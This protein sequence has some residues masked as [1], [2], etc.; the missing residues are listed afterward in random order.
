MLT[1]EYLSFFICVGSND[2]S[3]KGTA[4]YT[5]PT[6]NIDG[7]NSLENLDAFSRETLSFAYVGRDR[8]IDSNKEEFEFIPAK[9]A[10]LTINGVGCSFDNETKELTVEYTFAN[11]NY[12]AMSVYRLV[13]YGYGISKPGDENK[14]E[15]YEKTQNWGI[16]CETR[17]RNN[18]KD[19]DEMPEFRMYHK[20]DNFSKMGHSGATERA[21]LFLSQTTEYATREIN[22]DVYW[23]TGTEK[24]DKLKLKNLGETACAYYNRPDGKAIT[25]AFTDSFTHG[26]QFVRLFK[27]PE[28]TYPGTVSYDSGKDVLVTKSERSGC[29]FVYNDDMHGWMI[30]D[31]WFNSCRGFRDL[32][33]GGDI[34]NPPATLCDELSLSSDAAYV[35]VVKTDTGY[36]TIRCATQSDVN[37]LNN[38]VAAIRGSYVY[39][40]K[41]K[42]YTFSGGGVELSPT[43]TATWNKNASNVFVLKEDGTITVDQSKINL[44]ATTFKFYEPLDGGGLSFEGYDDERGLK[45]KETLIKSSAHIA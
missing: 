42:T 32:V 29:G 6:A 1:N 21:D 24:A 14:Q 10:Y 38:C 33:S 9:T 20:Y 2:K 44:N 30:R 5:I 40:R 13:R 41:A 34:Q 8:Y 15:E 16:D 31:A 7:Y 12:V 26:N 45:F 25:E 4:L 28:L 22:T 11:F 37:K 23:Y 17:I 43:I 3:E 35:A 27:M 36:N 39:D 19:V 18:T